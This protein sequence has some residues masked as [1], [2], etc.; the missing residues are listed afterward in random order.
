MNS[1]VKT[2]KDVI[3]LV[4]HACRAAAPFFLSI[5]VWLMVAVAAATVGGFWLAFMGD[6]RSVLAF[7]FAIGYLVVRPVL[8]LKRIL[9]WPFL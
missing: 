9:S 1:E 4:L 6:L 5:E 3:V 2:L 7:V 8:H